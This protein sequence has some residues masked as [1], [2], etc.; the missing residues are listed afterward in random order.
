MSSLDL[1]QEKDNFR[2]FYERNISFW[3]D[4]KDWIER[5][6]EAITENIPVDTITSRV[7]TQEGCISKFVRKYLKKCEDAK[8]EYEIKDYITD[9]IGL[10]IICL[11]E[12]DIEIIG[13][14]LKKNFECIEE[15]DKTEELYQDSNEFG[16]KGLHMDLRFDQNRLNLPEFREY[17]DIK[18]EVQIRTVTQHAWS[19]IEHKLRYKGSAI[20]SQ[21]G[22]RI[23]RLAALFEMADAEFVLLKAELFESQSEPSEITNYS[24]NRKY[25]KNEVLDEAKEDILNFPY[26]LE[27]TRA[28]FSDY[29]FLADKAKKF[30]NSVLAYDGSYTIRQFQEALSDGFDQVS[31]YGASNA[32][33]LNPYATLRHVLYLSDNE[34]FSTILRRDQKE[35]FD[36]WLCENQPKD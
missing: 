30:I 19:A 7:K 3:E 4:A 23:N 6:V 20:N 35:S 10:R 28:R 5:S 26:F 12:S 14:L 29:P 16:Y 13:E 25:N 1:N 18:F 17:K 11:Y 34:K 31:H 15:T 32:L 9:L 36:Q 21:T 22:R 33:N 2:E 24:S 8:T 27:Y